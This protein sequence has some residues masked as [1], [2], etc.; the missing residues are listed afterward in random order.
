MKIYIKDGRVC[1]EAET[2]SDIETLQILGARKHKPHKKH[3][4]M[5]VCDKCGNEYK[6]L[7][8]LAI[9]YAKCYVAPIINEQPTIQ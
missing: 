3:N 4:F 6:G 5:K 8:G 1:A 9:H 7:R 2:L